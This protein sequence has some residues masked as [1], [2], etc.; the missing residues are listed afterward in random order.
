[1]NNTAAV[2]MTDRK[3]V[4]L[5][6]QQL[7][8]NRVTYE[9][10]MREIADQLLPYR[11][12]LQPGDYN[13]GDRKNTRMYDGTAAFAVDTLENGFMN[14]A[15]DPA[16][17]WVRYTIKDA[18]RAKY[19]P[20]KEWLDELT[21]VVL[22]IL[23]EGNTYISL[24]TGYG[25]M[26]GF[27]TFAMSVT[28]SFKA[29]TINTEVYPTGSYWISQDDEANVNTFYRE[30]RM[31]VRQVYEQFG[32]GNAEFSP[33]L[34][35]L[36]D[37]S[38]WEQWID[39]GHM[40][41]PN[42]YETSSS[43]FSFSQNKPYASWWFELGT[44]A[45]SGSYGYTESVVN[46]NKFLRRSGFDSF[47]IM[48]GRWELTSGDTYAIDCP[49]MKALG[50]I[51]SLQ[52]Y[53]KRAAQGIEK[54]VNPHWLAPA[55][56]QGQADHGFIP[57]E[58]TYLPSA[59]E[60]GA[61]RPAHMVPPGFL[62]PVT[63]KE[64]EIRKRIGSA[65]FTD[66]FQLFD[67]LPD[68][69]R[70]ATEIMQRKSEKLTKLSKPYANLQKGTFRPMLNRVFQIASKRGMIRPA[71]PDLQGHALDYEY[72]GILAQAQ[73]MVKVQPVERFL[74]TVIQ[75][76]GARPQDA[77]VWDPINLDRAFY[78]MADGLNIPADMMNSDE[79][80]QQI[81]ANREQQ[82]AMQQ[83][84]AMAEQ[85]SRAAA[86]LGKA[87]VDPSTALGALAGKQ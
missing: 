61:V 6:V 37:H 11:L 82:Q 31:T 9:P 85:A 49:G 20:H 25:N 39:V 16:S 30:I 72:N 22:G 1:M 57:G 55:S 69:E 43:S 79:V 60:E 51:K 8:L 83:K 81:R 73:K 58:T 38:R 86:N 59:Q 36:V 45:S 4:Q 13:R 63:I 44:S 74:Q 3:Y 27:G 56:L 76:A 53:E 62:D 87:S 33:H 10:Q 40:I 14:A 28:E 2:P 46:Q 47:P 67:T 34:Q 24:P 54:V 71:P 64:A 29:S 52:N 41:Q 42:L 5:Q 15:S 32:D 7:K 17:V 78:E 68:K 84:L 18:E 12:R 19:G 77:S 75:V 66:L 80:V 21:Q 26:A 35:N 23:D 50:D 48:V 70:T 65:F